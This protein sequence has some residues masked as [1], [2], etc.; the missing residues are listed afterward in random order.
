MYT[1]TSNSINGGTGKQGVLHAVGG[2]NFSDIFDGIPQYYP[3]STIQV[4]ELLR[5]NV[6][7]ENERLVGRSKGWFDDSLRLGTYQILSPTLGDIFVREG[8]YGYITNQSFEISRISNYTVT[9]NPDVIVAK[10]EQIALD[11]CNFYL[12]PEVYLFPG[13]PVPQPGQRLYNQNP[14]LLGSVSLSRAP[15]LDRPFNRQIGGVGLYLSPGVVGINTVY[16]VAVIN[17]IY[18][19]YEST[20]IPAC[21]FLQASCEAQL[22]AYIAEF[23][24]QYESR[25]AC[26]AVHG[27]SG[28]FSVPWVCPTDPTFV[29]VLWGPY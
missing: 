27:V 3:G 20:P 16:K 14:V 21:E 28:C 15:L 1:Q 17:A 9:A 19:D 12:T 8:D 24:T 23:V 22:D 5:I 13:N 7:V 6:D 25:E 26:E 10:H 11:N 29:R 4:Q 18:V 2:I